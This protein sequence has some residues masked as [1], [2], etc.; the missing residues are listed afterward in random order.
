[1]SYAVTVENG[2]LEFHFIRDPDT[3]KLVGDLIAPTGNKGELVFDY[4]PISCIAKLSNEVIEALRNKF[5][6][7]IFHPV[8]KVMV[9][10]QVGYFK[11]LLATHTRKLQN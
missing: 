1:M 11:S 10:A 4:D 8:Y 3:G 5:P 9:Y 6:D 7:D 2:D